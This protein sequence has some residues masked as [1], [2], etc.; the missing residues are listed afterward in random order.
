LPFPT[1][2]LSFSVILVLSLILGAFQWVQVFKTTALA[3]CSETLPRGERGWGR[4]NAIRKQWCGPQRSE[5]TVLSNGIARGGRLRLQPPS[6][7]EVPN[8]A[9][10]ASYIVR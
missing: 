10:N 5:D 3:A 4:G 8:D 2:S 7:Q 1:Q 6:L 9:L